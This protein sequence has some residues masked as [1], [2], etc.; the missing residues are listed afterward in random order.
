VGLVFDERNRRLTPSHTVKGGKRYRYYVVP[1]TTVA[2]SKN[3]HQLDP[4][5]KNRKKLRIP[6][7][8]LENIVTGRI[9]AFLTNEQQLLNAYKHEQFDATQQRTL[10]QMAQQHAAHWSKLSPA[11]QRDFLH[12]SI[13]RITVKEKEIGI[14]IKQH[15]LIQALLPQE[16]RSK[17]LS[18]DET[19]ETEHCIVLTVQA[20]LKR[21]GLEVRLVIAGE[22][23]KTESTRPNQA[24]IKAIAR[25][26][27]W[28]EQLTSHGKVS[29]T[30]LAIASGVN[31]TYTSRVLRSAFLAPDIVEAILEGR[32]PK[33]LTLNKMLDD[34]PLDWG[35]QRR[36][37]G[38]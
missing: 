11:T 36:M 25:G 34:L 22:E 6:A 27:H 23:M 12:R 1:P 38:V 33:G 14:H 31:D 9:H 24:L 16:D 29:L 8:D 17:R 28:Y 30:D 2:A 26:R 4:I 3:N 37:W 5:K 15:A 7:Q 13:E 32:Q 10:I 20:Q 35:E 19:H 21:C 18:K